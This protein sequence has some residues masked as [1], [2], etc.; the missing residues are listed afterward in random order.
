[1]TDIC[2]YKMLDMI[3]VYPESPKGKAFCRSI[4]SG[5]V[6]EPVLV[7]KASKEN[8]TWRKRNYE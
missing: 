2:F 8:L 6:D 5:P 3:Y 7:L 1:M 4:P